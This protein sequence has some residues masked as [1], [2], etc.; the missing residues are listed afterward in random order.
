M[1]YEVHA[2]NA[3]LDLD[4]DLQTASDEKCYGSAWEVVRSSV[5][6]PSLVT[7]DT[8]VVEPMMN[9]TNT[10][11]TYAI[12]RLVPKV[13]SLGRKFLVTHALLEVKSITTEVSSF[14]ML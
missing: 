10:Q 8:A 7:I 9:Q 1:S 14:P 12:N 5:C 4:F 6:R 2:L 3:T 13:T 11:S